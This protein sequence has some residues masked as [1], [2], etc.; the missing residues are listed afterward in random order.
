MASFKVPCPSCESEVLIKSPNLVGTKVECPKCKYRFKVEEPAGGVPKDEPK[1]GKSKKAAAASD[2]AAKKKKTKKMIAIAAG[3]LAVAVLAIVGYSLSGGDKT[4]SDTNQFAFKGAN[5]N[6]NPTPGSDPAAGSPKKDDGVLVAPK[7]HVR[8]K[9]ALPYSDK[10]ASNLLPGQ[11]VSLYRFEVESLTQTPASPLFDKTVQEMFQ[12][13]MG[14]SLNDVGVYYHA[15]V[16]ETRDPFGVIRLAEP[17]LDKDVLPRMNLNPGPQKI[18]GR[19]L[20][21][22]RSNPFIN[23]VANAFSFGSIFADLYEKVPPS[24]VKTPDSRVMGVCFYDTEHILIGDHGRLAKFLQDLESTGYP[25]FQS[26]VGTPPAGVTAAYAE[27]AQ[28][29]SVDPKMKRLMIDLGAENPSPPLVVYAE[30]LVPGMYDPKLLKSDFQAVSAALEPVISRAAFLGMNVTSFTSKQAIASV[31]LVMV[32]DSAAREVVKEQLT[33]GLRMLTQAMTL[34]LGTP[35]DFVNFTA[36]ERPPGTTNPMSPGGMPPSGMMPPA[37]MEITGPSAPGTPGGKPKA[38]GPPPPPPPSGGVTIPG[39]PGAGSGQPPGVGLPG[40]GG[41]PGTG[42]PPPTDPNQL[43]PSFI[44]LGLVDSTITITIELNWNDDMYRRIVAPRL[45]GVAGTLKG[46]MSVFASDLSYHALAQAVPKM[47]EATKAFPRGTSDRRLT[48]PSRM[49]L[50]YPP[51]TRV[52]FFVEL[53]PYLGRNSLY[54]S[55]SKDLGWFD[56]KNLPVGEAWVPELLVPTYPQTAWRATSPFISDGRVLG[57]TNYVAIAGIGRDAAR[58]DPT[59]EAD[60]KRVG[61]T[62]YDWGSKVDE[63]TDGLAN[64]IYLMQ[65]PPGLSQPWI[66]GGGATVR[67]LDEDDPLR[68]FAHTYGTP[69]GKPGTFALMGN[70]DVRFIPADIKKDL[71]LAMA[72]RAGGEKFVADRIDKEAPLVSKPKKAD[73]EVK[74][75]PTPGATPMPREKM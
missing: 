51:Q 1:A 72:T 37:G 27:R 38:P 23:G 49:G 47:T 70:G 71:L 42:T 7:K 32:S 25:K 65:T 52:S 29:L 74:A 57:G 8:P 68:G 39:A 34:L 5:P 73:A 20:Y 21:T 64:T 17:M 35:V 16:G 4:K 6:P 13:S 62:G 58:Y 63:V 53:L 14:F 18:K 30:K 36:G 3:V 46:K 40:Q 69:D 12:A 15:F 26:I 2:A 55:A 48:D 75:E 22:F 44:G 43:P 41:V 19:T 59:S 31:Q 54:S 24:P 50:R 11:T 28:Y 45:M 10:E 67:G 60:K 56:E 61:I 66:S 9:S 33:P